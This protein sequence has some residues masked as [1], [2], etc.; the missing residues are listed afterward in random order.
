MSSIANEVG[1]RG[2]GGGKEA[3]CMGTLRERQR[4]SGEVCDGRVE[5]GGDS[6]HWKRRRRRRRRR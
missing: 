1:E 6:V 4:G 5:S 2:W 3:A